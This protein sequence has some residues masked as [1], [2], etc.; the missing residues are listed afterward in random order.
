MGT[1]MAD[2]INSYKYPNNTI[3]NAFQGSPADSIKE[4]GTSGSMLKS[5]DLPSTPD[6]F[7]KFTPYLAAG[8]AT[9]VSLLKIT[10]Y[11]TYPKNQGTL[12]G[13][14]GAIS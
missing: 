2:I 4:G 11:L 8:T 10:N 7:V 14:M 6:E 3:P 5:M 1:T 9:G 13:Q 12:N